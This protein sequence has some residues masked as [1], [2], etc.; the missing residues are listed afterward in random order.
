MRGVSGSL[1]ASPRVEDVSKNSTANR[2]NEI[3]SRPAVE[4]I[5]VEEYEQ[6]K[7]RQSSQQPPPDDNEEDN[8]SE[9]ED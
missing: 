3:T 8:Y 1:E 2:V 6:Q 9:D 7:R 4:E 5:P